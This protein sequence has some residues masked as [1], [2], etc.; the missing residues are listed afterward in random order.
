MNAVHC[1]IRHIAEYLLREPLPDE[2]IEF[3]AQELAK[4]SRRLAREASRRRIFKSM[5]PAERR[6]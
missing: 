5:N 6:K 1:Q 2:A 3:Y 4:I